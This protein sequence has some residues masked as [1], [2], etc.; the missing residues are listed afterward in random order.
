[1]AHEVI[2]SDSDTNG[3][4]A[5]S[6]NRSTKSRLLTSV[7]ITCLAVFAGISHLIWPSIHID[8]ILIALA[9]VAVVPWLGS[10]M[11]SLSFPGGWQ[12]KYREIQESLKQA[13]SDATEAKGAAASADRR[14][15]FAV[16]ATSTRV[17]SHIS[18]TD[19]G[20]V[21]TAFAADE[22]SIA[23]S[24]NRRVTEEDTSNDELSDLVDKYENIREENGPGPGRTR[25]MTDVVVDMTRLSPQLTRFDWKTA[26][27]SERQ[28]DRLSGYVYL[29]ARPIEEG[30]EELTN[31]LL[32]GDKP[33]GE[34]WALQAL[35]HCVEIATP[36]TTARIVPLLQQLH[37]PAGTDRAYELEQTLRQIQAQR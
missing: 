5:E 6:E 10:I 16:A 9:V 25:Q 14:A 2:N 15:E 20:E 26:L 31:A 37:F 29:Y 17:P 34:Y 12:I 24:S 35:Q 30:A 33:F 19:L 22:P 3:T 4:Q 8:G 7:I 32:R 36:P 18:L 28:G 13:K 27:R 1:M 11:D 23:T 21:H